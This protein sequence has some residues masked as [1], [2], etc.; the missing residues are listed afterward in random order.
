MEIIKFFDRE[1]EYN[2]ARLLCHACD[3]GWLSSQ[4]LYRCRAV[5]QIFHQTINAFAIVLLDTVIIHRLPSSFGQILCR[6]TNAQTCIDLFSSRS[7]LI[8]EPNSVMYCSLIK[9]TTYQ[10]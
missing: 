4:D 8:P 9:N 3:R 2:L 10:D 7:L 6:I 5:S 1:A